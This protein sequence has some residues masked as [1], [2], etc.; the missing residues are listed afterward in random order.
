MTYRT[1]EEALIG[2]EICSKSCRLKP[3]NEDFQTKDIQVGGYAD[4]E[5]HSEGQSLTPITAPYV[6]TWIDENGVQY[7]VRLID[8][9]EMVDARGPDSNKTIANTIDYIACVQ[10]IHGIIILLQPNQTKLTVIFR[11]CLNELFSRLHRDALKNIFFVFPYARASNFKPRNAVHI[12]CGFLRDINYKQGVSI[13]AT[14]ENMFFLDTEAFLHVCKTRRNVDFDKLEKEAYKQSWDVSRKENDRLFTFITRR[15]EALHRD[16]EG[17][18]ENTLFLT[19]DPYLLEDDR[20]SLSASSGTSITE[21]EYNSDK[22]TPTLIS[23]ILADRYVYRSI[24]ETISLGAPYLLVSPEVLEKNILPWLKNLAEQRAKAIAVRALAR[25]EKKGR[26]KGHATVAHLIA[27]VLLEKEI[28]RGP[29]PSQPE[30]EDRVLKIAHL[31]ANSHLYFRLSILG[32]PDRDRNPAKNDGPLP[33]FGEVN[34]LLRLWTIARAIE[35][36]RSLFLEQRWTLLGEIAGESVQGVE[37]A[38]SVYAQIVNSPLKRQLAVALNKMGRSSKWLE[39]GLPIKDFP[40]TRVSVVRD[41]KRYPCFWTDPESDIE[42][43]NRGLKFYVQALALDDFLDIKSHEEL[44]TEKD[45]N[46][47]LIFRTR[48]DQI[49]AE[50]LRVACLPFERHRDVLL[51]I[52]NRYSFLDKARSLDPDGK[53]PELIET[54]LHGRWHPELADQTAAFRLEFLANIYT[55]KLNPELE[56]IRQR[57]LWSSIVGAAQYAAAYESNTRSKN[58]DGIDDVEFLLPNSLRLSIHKKPESSGHFTIEIGPSIH[59]TPWHGT[60]AMRDSQDGKGVSLETRLS[61]EL[62]HE[63]YIPVFVANSK[64]NTTFLSEMATTY[65]PIVWLAAPVVERVRKEGANDGDA[66]LTKITQ[67]K[68]RHL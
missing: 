42:A 8:T 51:S 64:A 6:T 30:R 15:Y 45:P 53:I 43:Y 31:L 50:K 49:Y 67:E 46:E 57:V 11:Y 68:L 40:P 48:R 3:V 26:W 20:S 28:R 41:S 35:V 59:R 39:L 12:L 44:E 55:P 62:K 9:L 17:T 38:R 1:F 37:S 66:I 58:R 5:V 63:S 33:D 13:A 7:L 56:A 16:L 61:L 18:P 27:E 19:P 60:A 25:A 52:S 47:V 10:E 32:F 22:S 4:H 21:I 23:Q 14:K 54:I 65:Q 36:S 34:A 29:L 24:T 2:P